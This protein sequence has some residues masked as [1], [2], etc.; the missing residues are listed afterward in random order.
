MRQKISATVHARIHFDLNT[1]SGF[2][3]IQNPFQT[4]N[5]EVISFISKAW[6]N[7]SLLNFSITSDQ[8]TTKK[9]TE[10]SRARRKNRFKF[11]DQN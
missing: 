4:S 2:F 8:Q 6:K 9:V 3:S 1:N 7:V 11:P 10:I 5:T